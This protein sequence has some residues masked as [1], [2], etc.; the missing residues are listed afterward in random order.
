MSENYQKRIPIL[1]TSV[2]G[3]D[4]VPEA[5]FQAPAIDSKLTQDFM[6]H[7]Q[8][9]SDLAA[10]HMGRLE[11]QIPKDKVFIVHPAPTPGDTQE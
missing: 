7:F 8:S 10:A 6:Q 1:G 2:I 4:L 11:I 9:A 5:S 3:Y